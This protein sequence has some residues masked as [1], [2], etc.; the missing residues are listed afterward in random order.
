MLIYFL[1]FSLFLI[2]LL[3]IVTKKN[4]IKIIVSLVICEYAVNL[5][6]VLVGYRTGGEAP[7]L[8]KG[9][10][11]RLMVD[12]LPQALVLTSIVI[13]LAILMLIIALCIKVYEKYGTLD[14]TEIRKLRG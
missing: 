11:P 6:I 4:L 12:P 5:F 10:A 13:G 14:I 2:G 1:C 7:I 9:V 8:Q 3:G